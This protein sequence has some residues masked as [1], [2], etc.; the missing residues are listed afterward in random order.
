MQ[1]GTVES[2][3]QG[4]TDEATFRRARRLG[5]S[6]IEAIL[7][8]EQ[9]RATSSPR[10]SSLQGCAAR[11]AI[12]VTSVMLSEHNGGGIASADDA[13]AAAARDDVL[14]AIDWCAELGAKIVLVPFFFGGEIVT[15]EDF[16]RA[17]SGF[18]DLCPCA[19]VKSVTL[20]YE[21]TLPASR[22]RELAAAIGSPAFGCYFDLANVI[23]RGLDTPTEIRTLGDL[24]RMVHVKDTLAVPGDVHPGL[25]RVHFPESATALAEVGYDGWLV[26][27]TPPGPPELVARDISFTRRYFSSIQPAPRWPVFG[28]FSYGYGRGEVDRLVSE[29]RECGLEAV[30]L[31]DGILDE[32]LESYEAARRIGGTLE[33]SGIT[34]VGVAGYRNL[35]ALDA[36]K[37][38]ANLRYIE[39]CLEMAP[40][41]GTSVVATETGTRSPDGDWVPSPD[42]FG[43]EAW[44][45]FCSSIERLL[46]V[47]EQSGSIL[48][49]EGY[50]NNVL[51]TQGQLAGLLERFKSPALQL[52]LDPFNY[53]S[54][55]VLPAQERLT[56]DFLNR[57][58]SRF[59]IAHLKDVSEQGAEVDTP[60]IGKGV[61]EYKPYLEFLQTR[62]PDLALILEHLPMEH[63]PSA[64]DYVRKLAG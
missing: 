11:H 58:E 16:Q 29:F 14:R 26:L 23:W 39:R 55:H 40:F 24:I 5:L 41:L 59:V 54:V 50:V 62:R 63:L 1:L 57:F 10:L 18:R 25:G 32:A 42:N 43:D 53:L 34:V 33:E 22:I 56:Q 52:V 7:T 47:A 49:L 30:Q 36:D 27:E 60:E 6:G 31:G 9:L 51:Q 61:F 3:L 28:A 38:E 37:R 64:V 46:T 12:E 19:A 15:D 20:C 4:R 21:G 35:T 13:T 48:A 17:V 44:A 2:V 8:R 45:V